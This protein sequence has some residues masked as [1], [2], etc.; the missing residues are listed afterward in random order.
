[1][2]P[3][4]NGGFPEPFDPFQVDFNFTE[5]N[6][7]QYALYVPQDIP[8]LVSFHG[9]PKAFSQHLDQMFHAEAK[10][11]GREQADIT[12]LI[13]QY[14]HGNEPSHHAAFLYA[15]TGFK[16]DHQKME[17]IVQRIMRELYTTTP[18]GLCGNEDCGQMS[19]WYVLA[20]NNVYS[21]VPGLRGFQAIHP[22]ADGRYFI[23]TK[24]VEI[25]EELPYVSENK[26][27]PLPI[28]MGPNS[29]FEE[30]A[31]VEIYNSDPKAINQVVAGKSNYNDQFVERPTHASGSSSSSY[32]I[33][34]N[35]LFKAVSSAANQLNS[36]TSYAHF[37]K[38]NN[39]YKIIDIASYDHQYHAGGD[40][41]LIDGIRGSSDFR[42]GSWQG[43]RDAFQMTIDLGGTMEVSRVTFSCLE[44]IK[45]WI[46][47]PKSIEVWGS[48]DGKNFQVL[49][50]KTLAT[51]VD[52]YTPK[53]DVFALSVTGR[54]THL[55]FVASQQY[56]AIPDWHLGA[57]GSSWIFMDEILIDLKN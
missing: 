54:F 27:T 14:A 21:T 15:H 45:S 34:D 38:K 43:Y 33:F 53:K 49:T 57:G 6:A 13:G 1:M 37:Y 12:G 29:A 3:R 46:W 10:T 25:F 42:I 51:L 7:W 26:I 52:D 16:E 4:R 22:S 32:S 18:D 35:M 47:F 56:Q 19:A 5:A 31:S 11:T 2:R 36:D 41:A 8:G 23:G 40:L 24:P 9:G 55:R 17:G 39:R 50:N 28:I 30:K 20:K 48:T 44:D